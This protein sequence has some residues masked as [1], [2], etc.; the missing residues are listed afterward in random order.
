MIT[1]TVPGAPQGKG[2]PRV[3]KVGGHAR[4]FTPPKTAA[5]ESLVALA[6]KQAMGDREPMRGPLRCLLH[7]MC[8]IPASW[9]KRK[10]SQAEMGA[11]LP[12]GKPDL[13][14]IAKAI[15]DGCN[16]IAWGDDS[17]VTSLEVHKRYSIWPC[18]HVFVQPVRFCE[19]DG[20]ASLSS[21]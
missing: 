1:F 18:V 10:R 20:N 11:L 3:G 12:A 9:A 17:Q 15:L 16:G 19:L 14:N 21:P 8:A 7:V 6:A 4:M 13:D 5:Y 2:R